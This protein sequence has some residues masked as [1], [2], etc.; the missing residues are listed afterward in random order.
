MS[1]QSL[2]DFLVAIGSDPA[3]RSELV[4]AIGKKTGD[5]AVEA[6]VACA[7]GRGYDVTVAEAEAVRAHFAAA[8]DDGVLGDHDLE[9][10]AGGLS[11]NGFFAEMGKAL[12]LVIE[13]TGKVL[14]GEKMHSFVGDKLPFK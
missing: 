9:G 6:L 14:S 8:N 4:A 11:L 1:I 12:D 5:D 3:G 7:T 10:V 13:S 2:K